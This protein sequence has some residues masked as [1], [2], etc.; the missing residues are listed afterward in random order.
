MPEHN[1][2]MTGD[3]QYDGKLGAVRN[4]IDEGDA[5]G[6]ADWLQLGVGLVFATLTE[7]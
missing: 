6:V 2:N 1:D 5:S 4:A 7:P 3:R